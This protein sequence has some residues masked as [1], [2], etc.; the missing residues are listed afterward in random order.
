MPFDIEAFEHSLSGMEMYTEHSNK[1]VEA[2]VIRVATGV[3]TSGM[4]RPAAVEALRHGTAKIAIAHGEVRD[5]VVR[6]SIPFARDRAFA[7]AGFRALGI[8]EF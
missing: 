1:A 7:A 5:T 4:S 8:D 3:A 6:E 2:L